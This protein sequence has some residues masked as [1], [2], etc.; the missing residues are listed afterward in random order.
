MT[1]HTKEQKAEVESAIEPVKKAF[2]AEDYEAM[3]TR[4]NAAND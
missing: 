4:R 1:H 2:E 3:K